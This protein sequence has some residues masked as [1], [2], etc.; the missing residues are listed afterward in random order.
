MLVSC[1]LLMY[2]DVGMLV[3]LIVGCQ[4]LLLLVVDV[5]WCWYVGC[6]GC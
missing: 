2:V 4:L 5:Y 3:V 1:W 6:V